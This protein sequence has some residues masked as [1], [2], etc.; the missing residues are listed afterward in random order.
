MIFGISFFFGVFFLEGV[1][2][3]LEGRCCLAAPL[4]GFGL[5]RAIDFGF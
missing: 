1:E 5:P 4:G 2:F 3:F